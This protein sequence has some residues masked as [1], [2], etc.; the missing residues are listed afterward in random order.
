[1]TLGEHLVT[2]CGDGKHFKYE[3]IPMD[4]INTAGVAA[5]AR[6]QPQRDFLSNP[7]IHFLI[8][9]LIPPPIRHDFFLSVSPGTTRYLC[10]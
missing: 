7:G 1:M 6:P 3:A 4:K 2:V 8:A 9:N 5:T 10:V